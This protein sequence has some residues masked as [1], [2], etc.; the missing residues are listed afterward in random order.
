MQS[1]IKKTIFISM[2]LVVAAASSYIASSSSNYAFNRH[3]AIVVLALVCIYAS[4]HLAILSSYGI[5]RSRPQTV[6]PVIFKW[7]G[8][9]FLLTS[10]L[11]ALTMP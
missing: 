4:Q 10:L 6:P 3:T 1:Q 5:S 9:L 11:L 8:W 7:A 2:P